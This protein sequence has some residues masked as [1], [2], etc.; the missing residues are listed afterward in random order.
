MHIACAC[1]NPDIVLLLVLVSKAI[2]FITI[3][4]LIAFEKLHVF[5]VLFHNMYTSAERKMCA[6]VMTYLP[7]ITR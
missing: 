5:L 6:Y 3:E 2:T 4:D 1:D 7:V